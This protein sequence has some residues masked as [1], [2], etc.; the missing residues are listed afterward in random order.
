MCKNVD[1]KDI[2]ENKDHFEMNNLDVVLRGVH[3]LSQEQVFWRVH[4]LGKR[5]R[6]SSS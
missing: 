4:L 1:I 6:E 2:C 3:T 5:K